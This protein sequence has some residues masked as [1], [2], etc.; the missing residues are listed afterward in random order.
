MATQILPCPNNGKCGSMHHFADSSAYQEC[1]AQVSAGA[2]ASNAPVS[3]PT[4][5]VTADGKVAGT[6][7]DAEDYEVIL[8]EFND[9]KVDIIDRLEER[10]GDSVYLCDLGYE[11]T[12]REN[13]DGGWCNDQDTARRY[14]FE[15]WQFVDKVHEN[16]E[17]YIRPQSSPFSNPNDFLCV[18]MINAYRD[19]FNTA[20]S[21]FDEWN[22]EVEIDEKFISRVKGELEKLN[23]YDVW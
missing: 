15:N 6:A 14:I 9:A 18:T 21:D 11:L 7:R 12:E 20:V 19:I 1:L 13:N 16:T 8:R 2:K 4:V 5:P 3:V 10:E 17:E 23:V 22:D